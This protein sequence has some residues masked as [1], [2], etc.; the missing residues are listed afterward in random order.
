MPRS[1]LVICRIAGIVALVTAAAPLAG[2]VPSGALATSWRFRPSFASEAEFDNNV[3]LL[4]D[5]KKASVVGGAEAGS[6]FAQMES[7]SDVVTTTRAVLAFAGPGIGGRRLSLV[8]E[9]GYE[10]YAQNAARRGL[11][12]GIGIT[13]KTRRGEALRLT[14]DIRPARFFKNYLVDAVDRDADGTITP[15]ER[16]YGSADQAET[17]LDADYTF[18]LRSLGTALR[19]GGGWYSRAYQQQFRARDLKGPTARAQ[20]LLE[21]GRDVRLDFGY[22]R[23]GLTAPRT[24]AVVLV[25]EPAF[26]R[27]FNGNGT[28]TDLNARAVAMV[29]HSRTE[30]ELSASFESGF[31]L[32]NLELEFA[33]RTR[34]YHSAEPYDVGNNGRRDARNEL[35]GGMRF[36][37][38][39][40]VRLRLRAQH[41]AQTV[42]RVNEAAPTG[43]VADYAR[44]RVSMG[45]EYRF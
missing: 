29:D 10:L 11:T 12:Y 32:A 18:A 14:A 1:T 15:D 27:D 42:N 17:T 13:Q 41:S 8:P 34:S 35:G 21:L 22:S 6:R 26:G 28:T 23:A 7:A 30:H 20:L 3:F 45:L 40:A 24:L 43:D 19:L 16:L 38:G 33:R 9:I 25:D 44:T 2:Q 31:G 37:L 4:P 5:K 39:S 36:D